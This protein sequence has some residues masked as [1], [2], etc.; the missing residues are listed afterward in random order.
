[1]LSRKFSNTHVSIRKVLFLYNELTNLIDIPAT[2]SYNKRCQE[3]I[4]CS[5]PYGY[6]AG[7]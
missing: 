3:N 2:F 1:M 7:L 6:S 5:L 4:G